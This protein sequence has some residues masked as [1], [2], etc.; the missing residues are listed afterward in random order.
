MPR[1]NNKKK[2]SSKKQGKKADHITVLRTVTNSVGTFRGEMKNG[3]PHGRGKIAYKDG[4]VLEGEFKEG[5]PH[6]LCKCTALAGSVFEGQYENGKIKFGTIKGKR[7]DGRVY[8]YEETLDANGD[9]HALGKFTDETQIHEGEF[10]NG[11]PHGK[12]KLT[13]IAEGV[14]FEGEW[15]NGKMQGPFIVTSKYG[16]WYEAVYENDEQILN[17][18][19]VLS[20]GTIFDGEGVW[21]TQKEG[22]ATAT[23]PNGNVLVGNFQRMMEENVPRK[24]TGKISFADGRV[25]EGE[26]V[27]AWKPQWHTGKLTL[28]DGAVFLGEWD[29]RQ[30]KGRGILTDPDG[31]VYV[32]EVRGSSKTHLLQCHGIG[33][34]TT[35]DNS[36]YEGQWYKD[37]LHGK[38]KQMWSD[39]SWYEGEFHRGYAHGYGKWVHADGSIKFEGNV[40]MGQRVRRGRRSTSTLILKRILNDQKHDMKHI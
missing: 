20:D 21:M 16:F 4:T 38:G 34:R 29:E 31:S 6:G 12:G 40:E 9:Y 7:I 35:V 33:K 14:V 11:I 24:W 36:T 10:K 18:R 19:L 22:K 2:T 30:K 8:V 26:F 28:P 32:G 13:S 3:I 5:Q 39:G 37:L 17:G 15:K 1:R 23:F 27:D 25:F